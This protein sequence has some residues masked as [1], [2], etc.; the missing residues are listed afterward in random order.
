M[1]TVTFRFQ[2][3]F[4]DAEEVYVPPPMDVS[5]VLRVAR[6]SGRCSIKQTGALNMVTVTFL[7]QCLFNDD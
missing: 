3:L 5:T 4:N 6:S 1:V 7:P 2:R